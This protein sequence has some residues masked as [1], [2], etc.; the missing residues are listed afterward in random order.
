MQM[1]HSSRCNSLDI[2]KVI[3]PTRQ[4]YLSLPSLDELIYLN[5]S[6]LRTRFWWWLGFTPMAGTFMLCKRRMLLS[7]IVYNVRSPTSQYYSRWRKLVLTAAKTVLVAVGRTGK[8]RLL[9]FLL[10]VTVKTCGWW[11]RLVA[12][13]QP[14]R[15]DST[16]LLRLLEMGAR[17]VSL[18]I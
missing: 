17:G 14:F 3:V 4:A 10:T 11:R 2:F 9:Q 15:V 5:F 8:R 7:R 12:L 13:H 6:K 1:W 18:S 16:Q